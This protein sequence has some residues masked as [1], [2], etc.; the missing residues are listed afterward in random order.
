MDVFTT[1]VGIEIKDISISGAKLKG[2][3]SGKVDQCILKLKGSSLRLP[4]KI[5]SSTLEEAHIQFSLSPETSNLFAQELK[6]R[7]ETLQSF[8]AAV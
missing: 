3:F 5:L 2:Q 7:F 6:T 1:P 4:G 8:G